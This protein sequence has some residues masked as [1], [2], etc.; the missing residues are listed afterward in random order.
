MRP[1]VLTNQHGANIVEEW[2]QNGLVRTCHCH[3]GVIVDGGNFNWV[4]ANSRYTVTFRRLSWISFLEKFG[5]MSFAMRCVA[6]NL[7]RYGSLHSVRLTS[8]QMLQGAPNTSLR[9]EKCVN[10]V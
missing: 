2:R 9:V 7:T 1:I 3:G 4:M 8:W 6:E 10:K 5:N